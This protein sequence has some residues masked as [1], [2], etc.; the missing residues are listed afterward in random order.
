MSDGVRIKLS[1]GLLVV[2]LLHAVAIV[3]LFEVVHLP[4]HIPDQPEPWNVP[5]VRSLE[6]PVSKL[7]EPATVNLHAQGEMK[8]QQ[9]IDCTPTY[10]PATRR[11]IR[12]APTYVQPAPTIVYPTPTYVQPVPMLPASQPSILVQ[13][14]NTTPQPPAKDFQLVLFIGSDAKSQQLL[15]WFNR[16]PRLQA[17]RKTCEF[18]V[19]TS[20]NPLYQTRFAQDVPVEQFPVVLL[21]DKNGGHIHAAGR[22]MIPGTVDALYADFRKGY[23]LYQQARQAQKTGAIKTRGYSWDAAI[24]P[25]MQLRP[26]DC[27]DGFCPDETDE[28]RRPGQRIRDLLFDTTRDTRDAILWTSGGEIATVV[29]LVVAVVLIGIIIMKRTSA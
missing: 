28:S 8:Q 7:T 3:G 20:S 9:C 19:F 29:L 5:V 11:I 10:V 6:P 25:T 18:Q 24:S 23:E 12:P 26:G 17:M 16:D 1:A 2:A 21:Q 15:D 27:P 22:S 13:P 14:I 4:R